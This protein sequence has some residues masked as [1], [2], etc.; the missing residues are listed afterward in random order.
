MGNPP[1]IWLSV[2]GAIMLVVGF[3]MGLAIS[4]VNHR[5]DIQA[6]EENWNINLYS[7]KQELLKS[8]MKQLIG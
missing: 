6:V 1:I 3:F 7:L 4:A 2:V 8:K 5:K